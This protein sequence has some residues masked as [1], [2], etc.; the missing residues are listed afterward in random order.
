MKNLDHPNVIKLYEVI[1]DE[2]G[3]KLYM[4]NLIDSKCFI[5]MDYAEHGEVLKWDIL[6]CIFHPYDKDKDTLSEQEIK[7]ILRHCIRGLN[8]CN[9]LSL[10][11]LI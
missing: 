10:L 8:Y 2:E 6:D 1:D 9:L 11:Y 5:V 4:G 3:D 7:K